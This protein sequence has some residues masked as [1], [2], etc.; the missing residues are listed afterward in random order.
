MPLEDQFAALNRLR[1]SHMR[2]LVT[3]RKLLEIRL[4]ALA[5]YG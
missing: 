5:A 4:T 1:L 2:D 3:R